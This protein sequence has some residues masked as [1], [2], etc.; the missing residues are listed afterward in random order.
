MTESLTERASTALA[1][2]SSRRSFLGRL[3]QGVVALVGGQFVA[4]ALAPD[5]AEAYHICGHTYTTGSCPHP[6]SPLSRVDKYGFPLHPEHGYPVD[7]QGRLYKS[8]EQSRRKMCAQVVPEKYPHVRQPGQGGGWSR[9][10]NGRIR[11]IYDCCAYT[12]TRI[13]GDGAV[14][15]YCHNGKKVFCIGY[16]D[17]NIRC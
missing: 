8:R 17:K 16:R 3:G 2:R 4:V 11:T 13:N 15:G 1:Q 10:C 12:R 7:D 6:Y 9:C 14:T 5:R